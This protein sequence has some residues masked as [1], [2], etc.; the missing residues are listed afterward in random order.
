MQN[1]DNPLPG[2]SYS[3]QIALQLRLGKFR[4]ELDFPCD[5]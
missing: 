4:L 3:I 1:R 5:S 2:Y